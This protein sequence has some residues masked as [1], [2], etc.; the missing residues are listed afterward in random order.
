MSDEE[1]SP[2]VNPAAKKVYS[3]GKMIFGALAGLCVFVGSVYAFLDNYVTKE[4]LRFN[5]ID[6]VSKGEPLPHDK[7]FIKLEDEL[8][9]MRESYSK[10]RELVLILKTT[11][12]ETLELL[13]GR[14]AA[15]SEPRKTLRAMRASAARESF[16]YHIGKGET[17]ID[18][19]RMALRTRPPGRYQR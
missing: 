13:A 12:E 8:K 4:D 15:D 3:Y 11:S 14:I 9:A 17:P 7:R 1:R 6:R 16:R 5:N 10:D 18:A 19:L 2:T